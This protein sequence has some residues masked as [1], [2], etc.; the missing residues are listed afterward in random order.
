MA[1]KTKLIEPVEFGEISELP[2]VTTELRMRLE[3]ARFD[4]DDNIKDSIEVISSAFPKNKDAIREYLSSPAI[5]TFEL[6]RLRGY[7]TGGDVAVAALDNSF[8]VAIEK[9]VDRNA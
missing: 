9:V 7:L 8:N 6:A 4:T 3:Q 1:F 2:Q 5:I